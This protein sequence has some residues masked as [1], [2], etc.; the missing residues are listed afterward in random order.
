MNVKDIQ[1]D[2]FWTKVN[3]D[4][5]ASEDIF[6][7][8]KVNFAAKVVRKYTFLSCNNNNYENLYGGITWLYSYKGACLCNKYLRACN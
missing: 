5:L 7:G 4:S 2:S 6:D 1:K 3:E 8:L